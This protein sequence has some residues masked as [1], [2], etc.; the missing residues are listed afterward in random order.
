MFK[1]NNNFPISAQ[2]CIS[3]RNQSKPNEWF[4]YEMQHW[5]EIG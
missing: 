1:V 4:L 2:Y 5:A 3:Y